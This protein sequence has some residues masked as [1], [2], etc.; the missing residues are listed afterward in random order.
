[1]RII[2]GT[3]RGRNFD[4]PK[5]RST[6]P[7][8]DRVKEAMFGMVQFDIEGR[9]VL[10]LF[11]GSGNLGLEALSRGAAHVVFC[12]N[13]RAASE[14]VRRNAELLG[15]SD[16]ARI[17]CSDCFMLLKQLSLEGMRFS[18]VLLDPPYAA[19]LT[20]RVLE[21]MSKLK[22]LTDGCIILAEHSWKL[23]LSIDI[24]GMVCREPRRYGDAAVTL[25]R[26]RSE[27]I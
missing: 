4:A 18:L 13:D 8:L 1:M 11:A 25:I 2:A 5:G 3:A 20:E 6:R 22:L 14:L 15:F 27:K 10:D 16:R 23:P 21:D 9:Q 7:T 26:Y 12:D 24:P 19:G 17:V